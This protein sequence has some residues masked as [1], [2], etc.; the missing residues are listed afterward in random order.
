MQKKRFNNDKEEHF[1]HK[2]SLQA[3]YY[4]I[5]QHF[6]LLLLFLNYCLLNCCSN[7]ISHFNHADFWRKW[8][9]LCDLD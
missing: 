8:H 2:G 9:S 5:L 7:L 6:F 1:W 4:I 3:I